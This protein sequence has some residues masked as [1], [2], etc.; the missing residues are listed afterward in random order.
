MNMKLAETTLASSKETFRRGWKITARDKRLY[1]FIL[2]YCEKHHG[3]FPVIRVIRE[4]TGYKSNS[5]ARYA[6]IKLVKHKLLGIDEEAGI[7]YVIGSI[8]K[9]GE[10]DDGTTVPTSG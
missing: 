8:W 2:S 6:L 9:M 7:Y 10:I 3:A 4:Y 5:S 1:D